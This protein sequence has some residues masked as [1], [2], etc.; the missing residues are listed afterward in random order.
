MR[1]RGE[2]VIRSI[3]HPVEGGGDEKEDEAHE[4]R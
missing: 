1:G 2:P 3:H 4:G